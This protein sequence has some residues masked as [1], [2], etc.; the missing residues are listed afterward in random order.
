MT[1]KQKISWNNLNPLGINTLTRLLSPFPD[2]QRQQLWDTLTHTF[3]DDVTLLQGYQNDLTSQQRVLQT[4]KEMTLAEAAESQAELGHR[5]SEIMDPKNDF[6]KGGL[7][8]VIGRIRYKLRWASELPELADFAKATANKQEQAK[9]VNTKTR[10][11]EADLHNQFEPKFYQTRSQLEIDKV[12]VRK[13]VEREVLRSETLAGAY[14]S[15][16]PE[17]ADAVIADWIRVGL[18]VNST[19]LNHF[20]DF[21]NPFPQ[22]D[23]KQLRKKYPWAITDEG[24]VFQPDANQFQS[25]PERVRNDFR[26]YLFDIYTQRWNTPNTEVETKT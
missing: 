15:I 9:V 1:E 24:V 11:Q 17:R 14:I 12:E 23:P 18:D 6:R 21:G 13:F 25:L 22:M 5:R 26:R 19:L 4:T 16:V 10:E 20:R 3:L 7:G 8:R 2:P